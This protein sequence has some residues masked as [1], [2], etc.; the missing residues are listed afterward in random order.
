MKKRSKKIVGGFLVV[1]LIATIGAV[2]ASAQGPFFSDL[3]DEQKQ[4]MK[5]LMQ[6]LR[7]EGKTREEIRAEIQNQLGEYGIEVPAREEILDKQIEQT[8]QR[9]DILKRIKELIQKNPEITQEEISEIIQSEF[10]LEFP[11]CEGRGM[12]F[13]NRGQCGHYSGPRGFISKEE[14]E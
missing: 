6:G 11:E 14:S 13:R 12:M 2:V 8:Q 3:T 10:E 5:G 7:D 1:T 4:E 9:L